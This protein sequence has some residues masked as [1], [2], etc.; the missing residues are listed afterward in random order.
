MITI[1]IVMCI[2]MYFTYAHVTNMTKTESTKKN[3][4]TDTEYEQDDVIIKKMNIPEYIVR[5]PWPIRMP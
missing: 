1:Y 5:K 3:K 2:T 4:D